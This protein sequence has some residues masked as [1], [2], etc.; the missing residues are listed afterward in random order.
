MGDVDPSDHLSNLSSVPANPD[1]QDTVKDFLDYTEFYPSDLVRSL[2]LIGNLDNAYNEL[3]NEI[4]CLTRTYANLPKLSAD[5]KPDP[6]A[7]RKQISAA[8]DRAIVCRE[9]AYAE[10]VRL[11]DV[12]ERHQHRLSIIKKK[13]QALPE[14]PS[15]DPTPPPISPATARKQKYEAE[16]VQRLTLHVNRQPPSA[17]AARAEK[18]RGHHD[19]SEGSGSDSGD[20]NR[21]RPGSQ[22]KIKIL[23]TPKHRVPGMGTNVH[24]SV[25]GISTS[26]ALARLTPPPPDAVPGSK[27]APWFNLT[28][29][30][31]ALLRKQMK[32]N[33]IWIPSDVMIRRELA[34]RGRGHENYTKAKEQAEAT[35]EPFLDE[36]PLHSKHEGASTAANGE[37]STA[38]PNS[39][40]K[41]ETSIVN[42][43]MKLN[44]AKKLK[45][46]R[47]MEEANRQMRAT[48]D[49]MK[50]LFSN[51]N[52]RTPAQ[53]TVNPFDATVPATSPSNDRR[54]REERRSARKRKRDGD[55]PES[56]RVSGMHTSE[57]ESDEQAN[58]YDEIGEGP[59]PKKLKISF[60]R[61]RRDPNA[62]KSRASSSAGSLSDE[63]LQVVT[64]KSRTTQVPLAPE[65]PSTP[66]STSEMSPV[67]ETSDDEGNGMKLVSAV[68]AKSSPKIPNH[69]R[70]VTAAASR[71]RR[72]S[73]APLKE[74]SKQEYSELQRSSPP[75]VPIITTAASS[76]PSRQVSSRPSSR[77][78]SVSLAQAIKAASVEPPSRAELS[79]N[80]VASLR[81]AS[82][83]NIPMPM[84]LSNQSLAMTP[85]SGFKKRRKPAPGA[86]AAFGD[87]TGKISRVNRRKSQRKGDGKGV[88]LV[89]GE[90]IGPDEPRYCICNEISWGDM[91][92]CDN[93]VSVD[94]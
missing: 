53:P 81:R 71:P 24:S 1:A 56:S 3:T 31:M 44:E 68:E 92:A 77:G 52:A 73:T 36:D 70:Q 40:I 7:L 57:A 16:R 49:F 33:A 25:A 17:R 65:G 89:D 19:V 37:P 78:G 28:D 38:D 61:P 22:Q 35:G 4:H 46:T 48:G 34:R 55:S 85:G 29:Y 30:E 87:G 60:P 66:P 83:A 94:A 76:R 2:T 12:T 26:N 23:K 8:L 82:H 21:R 47:E 27:H 54:R 39:S 58:E 90:E 43:G 72:E 59:L 41:E 32:K 11:Y 86:V 88:I 20:D 69:S 14:P 5:I 84:S 80:R 13:L 50:T 74:E 6:Q 93:K 18:G 79:G 51:T 9:S 64:A 91:I 42:R 10:A 67:P 63:E 75:V 15:R 62:S 45:R